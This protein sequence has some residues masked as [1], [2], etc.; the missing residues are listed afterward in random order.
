MAHSDR[1]W[2]VMNLNLGYLFHGSINF[3]AFCEVPFH[4]IYQSLASY[5]VVRNELLRST[6]TL[7]AHW[8]HA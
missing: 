5:F 8:R 3:R 1:A 4:S 6:N 7:E 2:L